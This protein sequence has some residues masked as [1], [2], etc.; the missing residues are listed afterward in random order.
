VNTTSFSP[1]ASIIDNGNISGWTCDIVT[2]SLVN[3]SPV[4]T[5]G[6]NPFASG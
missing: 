1:V 5:K 6:F 3:F 4:D 2:H